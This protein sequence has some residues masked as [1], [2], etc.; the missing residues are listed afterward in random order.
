M[1]DTTKSPKQVN[2][3]FPLKSIEFEG[4]L[5]SAN[6]DGTT[7]VYDGK[8][9]TQHICK[10]KKHLNGFYG[11]WV[12][13]RRLYTHKIVAMIYVPNP[14][15]YPIVTHI[16]TITTNNHYK[17]LK[18]GTFSEVAKNMRVADRYLD[19]GSDDRRSKISYKECLKVAKR[20]DN[21]EPASKIAV[22]YNTSEMSIN[23]IRKKYS[24]R[25]SVAIMY[26]D[27]IKQNARNLL[28]AGNTAKYVSS[29]LGIAYETV[30]KWA[31]AWNIEYPK[32]TKAYTPEL[33][34]KILDMYN[35]GS[36]YKEIS[37]ELSIS[38]STAWKT[39]TDHKKQKQ[40]LTK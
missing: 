29:E 6:I 4:K 18:W 12:G 15:N 8:V 34:S 26:S 30:W 11:V 17:N 16:D 20:L 24:K 39:V 37:S 35:N 3:K 22:E 31:K 32:K 14:K 21:G 2:H 10:A 23:R 28:L 27:E 13:K 19:M 33:K 1:T 40:Y 38:Y 25:K 9:L 36:S 7:I 5:L